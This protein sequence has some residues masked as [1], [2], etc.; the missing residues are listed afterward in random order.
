MNTPVLIRQTAVLIDTMRMSKR[1]GVAVGTWLRP[2]P[3]GTS[4][5][6][7][8][9]IDPGPGGT[10]D[11]NDRYAHGCGDMHETGIIASKCGAATQEPGD[12]TQIGSLHQANLLWMLRAARHSGACESCGAANN[13]TMAAVLGD[14]KIRHSGKLRGRPPLD[15]R[16]R[17]HRHA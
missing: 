2:A 12:Q 3:E 15:L 17:L 16:R 14:A 9:Q 10:A 1:L 5:L 7:H 4:F 8:W 6:V 11:G 13:S